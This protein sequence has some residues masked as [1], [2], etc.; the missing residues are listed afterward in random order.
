MNPDGFI[1][2]E[3]VGKVVFDLI[4]SSMKDLWLNLLE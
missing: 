4:K 2:F 1:G 3:T